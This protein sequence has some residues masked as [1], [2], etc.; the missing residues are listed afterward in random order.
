MQENQQDNGYTLPTGT[1]TDEDLQRLLGQ[2]NQLEV[3]K[4]QLG[5]LSMLTGQLIAARDYLT[6]ADHNNRMAHQCFD[7]A[8][9]TLGVL[10]GSISPELRQA[11]SQ[12]FQ[13]TSTPEV[14]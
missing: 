3:E 8:V 13:P 6:I 7:A 10:V 5:A 2:F 14:G 9:M 11:L 1:L 12:I 4:Q